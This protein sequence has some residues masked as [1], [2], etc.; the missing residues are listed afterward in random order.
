MEKRIHI[1]LNV[2]EN[3]LVKQGHCNKVSLYLCENI[4]TKWCKATLQITVNALQ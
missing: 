4:Y 2:R 3:E 1:S